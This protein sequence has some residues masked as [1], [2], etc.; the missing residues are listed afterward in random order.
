MLKAIDGKDT[1]T[2]VRLIQVFLPV[3]LHQFSG[4]DHLTFIE[5]I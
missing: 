5:I 1:K 2:A 4:F 3:F